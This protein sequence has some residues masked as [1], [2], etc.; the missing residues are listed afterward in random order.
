[1]A[2]LWPNKVS[3]RSGHGQNVG[4]VGPSVC[5]LSGSVRR[6]SAPTAGLASVLLGVASLRAGGAAPF[7]SP[8]SI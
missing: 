5:I 7:L 4:V 2:P 6:K 3:S 1:M 8:L